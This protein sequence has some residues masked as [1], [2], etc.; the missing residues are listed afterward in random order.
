M[1]HSEK[2]DGAGEEEE[3]SRKRSETHAGT[4]G[5]SKS[6]FSSRTNFFSSVLGKMGKTCDC[7]VPVP[8]A[9]VS[10]HLIICRTREIGEEIRHGCFTDTRV[11]SVPK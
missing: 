7:V 6:A 1:E 10:P 5:T 8:C 9:T 2:G 4:D 11:F 3:E